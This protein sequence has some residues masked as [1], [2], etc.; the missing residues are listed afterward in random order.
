VC[1]FV[2]VPS[3]QVIA[4]KAATFAEEDAV[5]HVTPLCLAHAFLTLVLNASCGRSAGN[6]PL[7]AAGAPTTVLDLAQIGGVAD[8]LDNGQIATSRVAI[9]AGLGPQVFAFALMVV[10]DHSASQRERAS[11]LARLG[12]APVPSPLSQRVD[13]AAQ[14]VLAQL[15]AMVP[16]M[17]NDEGL[18]ST[19]RRAFE[20]QYLLMQVRLHQSALAILDRELLP[21]AAAPELSS[22]LEVQ[23]A[24]VE[25]HLHAAEALLGLSDNDQGI[26]CG[27]GT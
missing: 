1:V 17:G 7:G 2:L 23:R 25:Q 15:N 16:G 6:P 12:I 5:K 14:T 21:Q 3:L 22:L 13:D 26:G 18:A 4:S 9:D 19:R 10:Q 24:Q 27:T 11:L 8:A 20:C